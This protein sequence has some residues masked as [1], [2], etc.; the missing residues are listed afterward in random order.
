LPVWA[1][2]VGLAYMFYGNARNRIDDFLLNLSGG[3][4]QFDQVHLA[5]RTLVGGGWTGTGL[6]LGTQKRSLPEAH[7][8]YIFSVIGEEFGLLMCAVVVLLYFAIVAR[9]LFRL[10][11][12]RISSPCWRAQALSRRS[13]GRLSSTSSSICN[14]SR[15]RG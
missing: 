14:S 8:D 2:V 10:A 5:F 1:G 13:A 12:K 7:T 11:R 4:D 6:W 3:G 15:P 9:V